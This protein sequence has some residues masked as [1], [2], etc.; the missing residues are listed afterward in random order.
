MADSDALA[1][2]MR[3]IDAGLHSTGEVPGPRLVPSSR[4]AGIRGTAK[5]RRELTWAEAYL[6]RKRESARQAHQEVYGRLPRGRT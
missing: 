1:E 2:L 6:S 3:E 4:G 5:P